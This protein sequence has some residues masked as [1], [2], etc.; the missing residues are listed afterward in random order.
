MEH[1]SQGFEVQFSVLGMIQV[2]SHT[3]QVAFDGKSQ[4]IFENST[5]SLKQRT[6]S[7]KILSLRLRS[8]ADQLTYGCA[9]PALKTK[10]PN[11]Q[12]DISQPDHRVV[13]FDFKAPYPV[14]PLD[15]TILDIRYILGAH[16]FL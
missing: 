3:K 4:G 11:F 8:T 5:A 15:M 1:G 12:A 9:G 2:I 10:T 16:S 14:L 13:L 7:R 6:A